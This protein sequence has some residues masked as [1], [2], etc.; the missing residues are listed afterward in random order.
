MKPWTQILF[1]IFFPVYLA[2]VLLTN[3]SLT[4]FWTDVIFSILLSVFTLGL[5]FRMSIDKLWLTMVLRTSNILC[6]LIVFGLLGLHLVNPFAWDTFKLRS[7]YFQP[8]DSRLF[9]AYFKPVGAY[10]GGYGNFWVTETPKYF[11]LIEWR[12]YWDRTVD[13]DFKDDTFEGEPIDNYEVV[14]NFIKEEVIA[15][16]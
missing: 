14:R 6:S 2:T 15:K 10:A 13:H 3:T 7:F 5:N 4:G 16:Q 1:S 11:P 12:V 9:N 8:V